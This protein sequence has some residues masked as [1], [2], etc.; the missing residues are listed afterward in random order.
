MTDTAELVREAAE[1]TSRLVR[2]ELALA[3]AE[4]TE[5][6]KQA[7]VAAGLFSGGG[8]LALYGVAGL[9]ATAALGLDQ[10]LPA[11]LATLIVAVVVLAVAGVLA[12]LGRT[13]ATR[14]VP[15]VP[16]E[17]VSSVKADIDEVKE[18]ARR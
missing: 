3:R 6:G 1:Q 18:R 17:A 8:V 16:E 12:L 14:A 10:V 15:P 7:G 2:E 11:W 4:M 5:K 13:R 9:L